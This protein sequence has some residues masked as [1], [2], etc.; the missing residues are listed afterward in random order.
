MKIHRKPQA[1]FTLIEIMIVVAIIGLLAT[2]VVPNY[3]KATV[4]AKQKVCIQNLMQIDGAKSAW[5]A[6]SPASANATPQL[7]NI[8]SFLGRG[9]AGTAPYCPA[10]PQKSFATSYAVGDMKTSPTCLIAPGTDE[11]SHYLK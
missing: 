6:E 1:G 5:F 7:S 11:N 9:S 3:M 8:Q 4:S 10:D 2:I